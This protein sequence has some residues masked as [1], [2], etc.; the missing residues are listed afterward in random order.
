MPKH[1][2]NVI[3]FGYQKL[4]NVVTL[5]G[6]LKRNGIDHLV[7]VRSR[8]Y[9]RKHAFNKS[10]L[11]SCLPEAGIEYRW[12]GEDL[13]GFSEIAESDIKKLASWQNGKNACLVCMEADPNACHRKTEI[14]LQPPDAFDFREVKNG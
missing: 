12:A 7:D 5:V 2:F 1:A 3:S 4:K 13:G 9:G 8:P 10:K 14:A 11:E 6:I